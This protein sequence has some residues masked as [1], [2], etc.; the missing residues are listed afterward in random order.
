MITGEMK[1]FDYEFS[2]GSKSDI[3]KKK[4]TQL[5]TK[6]YGA[7]TPPLYPLEN[8]KDLP[9]MIVCGRNDK[10]CQ[11]GDYMKLKEF[12]EKQNS[13]LAFIETDYGHLGICNPIPSQEKERLEAA[14][15]KGKKVVVDEFNYQVIYDKIA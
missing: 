12:L 7:P 11:P 2:T 6:I 1:M 10:L 8:L 5:N 3:T 13:L 4:A 9:V 15:K 14:K